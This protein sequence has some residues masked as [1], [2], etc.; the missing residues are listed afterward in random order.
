MTSYKENIPSEKDFAKIISRIRSELRPPAV[1][2]LEGDLGSGK[3]TFVKEFCATIDCENITSPTFNL[4]NEY[5]GWIGNYPTPVYHL[6][7]YRLS[8]DDSMADLFDFL[9]GESQYIAFIEW[10]DRT[11]LDWKATGAQV[12]H[13]HFSHAEEGRD[14]EVNF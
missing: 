6:D 2:L 3:T 7:L 13:L 9:M 11:T 5:N 1:I 12:F 14:M 4:R 8:A 10:P